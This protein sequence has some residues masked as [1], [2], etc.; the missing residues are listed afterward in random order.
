MLLLITAWPSPPA[1]SSK[2]ARTGSPNLRPG[3]RGHPESAGR[4]CFWGWPGPWLTC[5]VS[6]PGA[7]WGDA[8]E[9]RSRP[10]QPSS[11]GKLVWG[12]REGTWGCVGWQEKGPGQQARTW[13]LLR[14][15]PLTSGRTTAPPHGDTSQLGGAAIRAPQHGAS[16][17]TDAG[18][19]GLCGVCSGPRRPHEALGGRQ[20]TPAVQACS[21]PRPSSQARNRLH[22]PLGLDPAPSPP[23]P[24]PQP[25]PARQALLWGRTPTLTPAAQARAARR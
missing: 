12:G 18:G 10:P 6:G 11:V 13:G 14:A 15:S 17:R 21:S 1:R 25:P 7:S 5:T 22:P 9:P 3:E 2:L 4:S 19:Q 23:S 8:Q 16:P 20:W 24:P